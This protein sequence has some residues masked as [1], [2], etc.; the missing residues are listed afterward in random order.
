MNRLY[1]IVGF[2]GFFGWIVL[3][4]SDGLYRI[5]W[6]I[7]LDRIVS[8]GL[9]CIVSYCLDQETLVFTHW[10]FTTGMGWMGRMDWMSSW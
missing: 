5:V 2:V 9:D 6:I 3:S 10:M 4:L 7:S 1:R 8:A